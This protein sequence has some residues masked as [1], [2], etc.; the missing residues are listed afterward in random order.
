MAFVKRNLRTFLMVFALIL[1]LGSAYF[2]FAEEGF[3]SARIPGTPSAST[4][5]SYKDK[6]ATEDLADA[7]T[8]SLGFNNADQVV[9][10]IGGGTNLVWVT[11]ENELQFVTRSKQGQITSTLT[12][13]EAPVSLPAIARYETLVSVGW[14]E[15]TEKTP[16]I[17][18]SVSNDGGAHFDEAVTLGTGSGLS[19]AASDGKIV[20]VWH[21]DT[22]PEASQILL[23]EYSDGAW[24][25]PTRVDQ[26][27][28]APLWASVAMEGEDIYVTWRDNRDGTYKV[29]LRRYTD[30]AWQEEQNLNSQNSADPDLCVKGDYVAVA[31]QGKGDITLLQ[32]TDGGVTFSSGVTVGQGYFA[33]LSCSDKATAI[34]WE[35]STGTAKAT[36]KQAGWALYT[37]TGTLIGNG[38]FEDVNV[39]ATTVYL[40]PTSLFV[41][42]LWIL[43]G[44]EPLVGTLRHHTL[45]LY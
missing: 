42:F 1:V 36:D 10:A 40:T 45:S 6:V 19:L 38:I 24:S 17:R 29:W 21:D 41:E 14:V 43:V 39:A 33:H 5:T 32:S 3:L 18:V 28:A 30:G 20:A 34:A 44:D 35:Y 31:H 9:E 11:S 8:L 12:L 23:S 15:Q 4:I 25:S 26:S 2:F 37:N 13:V 7:P 27:D 16:S 22:D